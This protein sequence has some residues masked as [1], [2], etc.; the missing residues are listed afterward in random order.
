[1]LHI[2]GLPHTIVSSEYSHCA[3]SGK[4]LR[5]AKM[6]HRYGW[7]VLEY[8]NEGSESEAEHVRILTKIEFENLSRREG[9]TH[10]FDADFDNHALTEAFYGRVEQKLSELTRPHDIVC[11]VFGPLQRLV[12]FAPE[13][14]HVESGIGYTCHVDVMPFRVFESE[15][16]RAWHSGRQH[17]IMGNHLSWVTPNYF[18]VAEWPLEKEPEKFFLFFGRIKCDKGLR[19]I[20]ELARRCPER[21]FVICGQGDPTEWLTE[22]NIEYQKPAHGKD[23]AKLL[24]KAAAVICASEYLEPFCGSCVEAQLCGTPVITTNFG[25]FVETV[26]HAKSGY[27]CRTLGD[28]LAALNLVGF[29]D[30]EY[31]SKRARALYSL[32]TVGG[33]Y[34]MIFKQIQDQARLGWYSK[35]SHML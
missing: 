6:M 2:I 14:F 34:D 9:E 24:G 19:I 11:H 26:E 18:D 8:S 32:E 30:R 28:F 31:I 35:E 10:F 16:W 15:I 5:F 33:I 13:C 12:P 4:I 25:A 23:R 29:L 3:F 27:R 1:M 21:R 20:L 22:S 7:R 17:N